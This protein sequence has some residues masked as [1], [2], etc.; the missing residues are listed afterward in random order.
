MSG[1]RDK[2]NLSCFLSKQRNKLT[3]K[4]IGKIYFYKIGNDDY[5]RGRKFQIS[6]EVKNPP[7]YFDL[8]YLR[9]HFYQKIEPLQINKFKF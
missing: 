9:L 5:Y 4:D 8:K 2:N 6:P 7:A 1:R 3:W